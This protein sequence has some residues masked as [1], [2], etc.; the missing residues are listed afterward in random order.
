MNPQLILENGNVHE[1]SKINY[2]Y[3]INQDYDTVEKVIKLCFG[4]VDPD[5]DTKF[6]NTAIYNDIPCVFEILDKLGYDYDRVTYVNKAKLHKAEKCLRF[7][8]TS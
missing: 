1:I 8:N 7:F 6:L 2:L 5:N 3:Y 4:N